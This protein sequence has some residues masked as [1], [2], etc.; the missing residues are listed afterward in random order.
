MNHI[1]TGN[2]SFEVE[3]G[4]NVISAPFYIVEGSHGCLPECSTRTEHGLLHL[5]NAINITSAENDIAYRYS[6]LFNGLGK[7]KDT[8]IK[9][10]IGTAVTPI[11]QSHRRIPFHMRRKVEE[12]LV[13]LEKLDIIK[14]VEGPTPWVSP[15]VAVPKPKSPNEVRI[16]I[17]MRMPHTAIQRERHTTPTLDDI[18][19]D[20]NGATVFSKLDLNNG[21]GPSRLKLNLVF[22]LRLQTK[23]RRKAC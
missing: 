6:E 23:D 5:A 9:L 7:L 3:S 11:V 2:P 13:R 19:C 1:I 15:I 18:L 8:K 20:L 10:N 4:E 12:E 16:C 14:K 22:L 17:D 21:A